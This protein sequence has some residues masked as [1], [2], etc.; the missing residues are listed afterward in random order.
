MV[1]ALMVE[2]LH[3]NI[4]SSKLGRA[5]TLN[6]NSLL[7]KRDAALRWGYRT[8]QDKELLQIDMLTPLMLPAEIL[9]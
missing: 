6:S 3:Q 9:C 2:S 7:C 4:I 1:L 8:V 5:N